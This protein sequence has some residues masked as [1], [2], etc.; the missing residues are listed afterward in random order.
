MEAR[1]RFSVRHMKK[2]RHK[3]LPHTSLPSDKSAASH[4]PPK[5]KL[6]S[7]GEVEPAD[8]GRRACSVGLF[9]C[10]GILVANAVDVLHSDEEKS[11]ICHRR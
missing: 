4:V 2:D 6:S 9:G 7:P 3:Y 10:P 1:C 8:V 5:D 11:A